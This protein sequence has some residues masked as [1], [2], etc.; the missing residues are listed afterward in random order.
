MLATGGTTGLVQPQIAS[1]SDYQP[2]VSK[3]P[4]ADQPQRDTDNTNQ[5]NGPSPRVTID[6]AA[7]VILQF[8]DSRG[9]T[10]F[11]SPAVAAVAYLR[12]GLTS[13]GYKPE[14]TS[15]VSVPPTEQRAI[16]ASSETE[17][18]LTKL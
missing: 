9:Q 11:Q 17:V 18:G 10:T 6:P 2:R 4:E 14:D 16:G 13:E 3:T 15:G 5:S 8:L 12:A 7:G 1:R